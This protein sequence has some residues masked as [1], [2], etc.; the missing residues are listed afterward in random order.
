[1]QYTRKCR[2]CGSTKFK[3][4]DVVE[5]DGIRKP[6]YSIYVCKDCGLQI[7]HITTKFVA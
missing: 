6:S 1:M 5:G 4:T 2:A 3:T 7:K